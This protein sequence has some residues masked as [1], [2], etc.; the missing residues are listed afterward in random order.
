MTNDLRH[1]DKEMELVLCGDCLYPI[2]ICKGC[3]S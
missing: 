1:K 3:L 2:S